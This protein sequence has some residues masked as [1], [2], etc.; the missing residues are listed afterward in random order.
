MTQS[1]ARPRH[2]LRRV[3]TRIAQAALVSLT[4][5][6]SWANERVGSPWTGESGVQETTGQIM[7][8]EEEAGIR[9]NKIHHR[10]RSDFQNLPLDPDS[11]QIENWLAPG[12]ALAPG[13]ETNSAQSVGLNFTAATLVDTQAFPPDS[14]GAVGPTQ[15]ILAVN[16][17][18]RSFDKRTGLADGVLNADTD[19]FFQ[20]VMTPPVTN[21][22][23]SDPRIRY[24]R[25]TGRWFITIIDVPGRAG[26]LPN[27]ILLAVSSG[28]VITSSTVWTYFYFQHD[29]VSPA[30]DTGKFADYPTLGV[31][32]Q[33]LYIGAN[34]F[35]T[36]GQGSFSDTT[37]YVIRKTSVLGAGPIVVTAFRGLVEKVQGINTGPYTPQGVDNAATNSTE[38]YFIGVD[39]GL[40]G[41]LALR[42]VSNPGGTPTISGNVLITIPLNGNT[43][44]IPHLGNTGGAAGNL[45]GLD[46]RLIMAQLRNGH[47]WTCA[48]LAVNNTGVPNSTDTRMG[49][50]WY[51]LGNIAP[52][53]T[54]S[55]IQSGT[56]Y[57]PSSANTTDRRN[58]WMGAINVT[59]QGHAA[60]GFSVAGAN[61]HINAGFA[62]R[63]AQDPLGSVR[64]PVLYT[65]SS[66]A[67]NPPG[68]SGGAEGRRWGDYSYTC[69]DPDDDMT[70]W[71][72]QQ[73]C[74]AQNSYGLRVLR[75]LAPPPATPIACNP[76]TLSAGASNVTVSVTGMS[77][78]GSG[79]FDAGASF[80]NHVS[81]AVSGSGVTVEAINYIDPTHLN[82]TV[83]VSLT[84]SAGPRALSITNPDGQVIQSAAGILN[85]SGSPP[86]PLVSIFRSGN[87]VLL[88]WSA[89]AGTMYR[90][91]QK[92]DMN[93][94][95][96][97]NLGGVITATSSTAEK[98]D[99]IEP[100]SH[101]FYRVCVL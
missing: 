45:D 34:I 57:D 49:V 5:L 23:T 96:W 80:S 26:A 88:R 95:S 30:G 76:A 2:V 40:Y 65:A 83:S 60:I 25:L 1:P 54:P 63:L 84:A 93:A 15:F 89:S 7:A 33:A 13:A 94:A 67:Y 11:P 55:V 43:I 27:R 32:A 31:D 3:I 78:N 4:V 73:F 56:V 75:I 99:Q 59:G 61:E 44:S 48:N 98:L 53:Q 36:R 81:A 64:E 8:R 70:L 82:L 97:Q 85:V 28:P 71:T 12:V 37:A 14:M 90:V 6:C 100:N 86:A 24:D 17:R 46:Y 91:Q 74:N 77:T 38:G 51:E 9:S 39:A 68:D 58:Y 22:F 79:F 101:R 21:N 42:R 47:L 50:R 10:H 35:G 18:V 87:S 69:V 16:G 29:L 19:V 41:R 20:S 52:G 92:T 72:V 66:T 62:G